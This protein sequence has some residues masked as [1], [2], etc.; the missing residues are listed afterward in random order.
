MDKKLEAKLVSTFPTQFCEYG[1]DKSQ[2][3]MAWG[4]ECG[5]GWFS[6]LWALCIQ[7]EG[8]YK[9][10]ELMGKELPPPVVFTQIKEKF[11]TLNVYFYGGDSTVRNYVNFAETM[12]MLVCEQCGSTTEVHQRKRGWVSFA[13]L[14]CVEKSGEDMGNWEPVVKEKASS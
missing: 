12:S 3:C 5:D 4:C 14:K 13:C 11:G 9:S 7:I 2:T 1:G 8:Y 6:L 10:L